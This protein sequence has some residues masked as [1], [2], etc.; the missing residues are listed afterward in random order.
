M[1]SSNAKIV[2]FLVPFGVAV[3]LLDAFF[4]PHF[5]MVST[6]VISA[7]LLLGLLVTSRVLSSKESDERERMLQLQ[8]DSVALY[9]VI[10]GL[11]AAAIL[12][13]HSEMA[14]VFWFV[15]GLAAIGR[16]TSFFLSAVQVTV[17]T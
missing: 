12:Y 5:G 3:Y 11:L 9:V 7:I 8:S 6:Q 2:Y 4:M 17:K 14:M 15:L 10:A 13:P 16:I 1:N